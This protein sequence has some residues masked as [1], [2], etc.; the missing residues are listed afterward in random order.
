MH[1]FGEGKRAGVKKSDVPAQ[2]LFSLLFFG[3]SLAESKGDTASL[4]MIT[5]AKGL[6]M[7]EHLV[8]ENRK[9]WPK[10][11]PVPLCKLI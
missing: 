10:A 6:V 3:F 8:H 9:L 2:S 7:E 5:V 1:H 11:I 4:M